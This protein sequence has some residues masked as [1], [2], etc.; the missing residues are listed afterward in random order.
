MQVRFLGP[1]G[2]VTGSCTWLRDVAKGW[3]FLVDCGMQQGERSSEAWNR[4]RWPFPPTEL[5]FVVLTHAHLDHCGLLPRLYR[6]GFGGAV[7]CTRETRDLA[8]LSL[9]DAARQGTCAYTEQDVDCINWREP[10]G[11]PLLGGTFHPVGQDLFLRFFR[12]GHI[13]GAVSVAIYWGPK[14]PTQRS[15]IFSG[16]LGGGAEG[17]ESLPLMRFPMHPV[18]CDFA[19]VESTYGGSIRPAFD[20]DPI[21]RRDALRV[22]LDRI[23][24]T[25]GVL[26]LPAFA[27]GRTQDVLFD[28]HWIVAEDPERYGQVAF[29]LDYPS[30]RRMH[31]VMFDGFVRMETNGANGKVRPLWLGKQSFR[32]LGLDDKDPAHIERMLDIVAVTLDVKRTMNPAVAKLGNRV[33][34][35]WQKLL[36]PVED[37]KALVEQGSGP[38]V[39]VT[40]SGSCEGGPARAWLPALLKKEGSVVGMLGYAPPTA[41][42]GQ[43]LALRNT[44]NS[45]R[46]RHTG[47]LEWSPDERI[48]IRDI[49]AE[50]VQV[51]GYSAH[52]DQAG[53]LDWLVTE[54]RGEWKAS[55]RK[56]YIQHGNDDQRRA[57]DEALRFRAVERGLDVATV[58]PDSAEQWFDLDRNGLPEGDGGDAVR[59]EVEIRRLLD[60]LSRVR[61]GLA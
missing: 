57:L 21:T 16:D 27:I 39:V 12:S 42:A 38:R 11:V 51:S 35:S 56:V 22:Q 41:M 49:K 40:G 10:G 43:L 47:Y 13:V 5:H 54:F 53:L 14:G 50:I 61:G 34:Q 15:I 24:A 19:V 60:E 30:A 28:L 52:A 4:Q 29:H 8:I 17:A 23:I 3:N 36:T 55:G 32:W 33:A 9:K 46:A 1:L 2:M 59:I 18:S 26:I 6:D 48:A 31:P 37:R 7:Y 58:L 45:E 20:Q 44:P 25:K